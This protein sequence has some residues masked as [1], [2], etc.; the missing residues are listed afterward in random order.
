MEQSTTCYIV[1]VG[2]ALLG[3]GYCISKLAGSTGNGSSSDQNTKYTNEM[4]QLNGLMGIGDSYGIDEGD[5]IW[6]DA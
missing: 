2:A 1:C 6:G 4:D 3:I 5:A